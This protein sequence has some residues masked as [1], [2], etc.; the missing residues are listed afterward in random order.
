M[1]PEPNVEN[2]VLP[3]IPRTGLGHALSVWARA[4]LYSAKG[5]A[6]FVHPDWFKLR[7]GPYLRREPDK[8]DYH[9]IIR[10]PTS[11]GLP[12]RHAWRR[13]WMTAVNEDSFD[14][15]RSGQ[16]LM[17]R[18]A[19]PLHPRTVG[20]MRTA[21]P[22]RR[23]LASALES[24][25]VVA[26]A[27]KRDGTRSIGIFHRSGDF[28]GLKPAS[29]DARTLR[30]HGYGYRP[31]EYAAEALAKLREIAGWQVPAVLSTD[32]APDEV[33]V[34]LRQGG[35]QLSQTKSALA[36]MLEMS[37]HDALIIGTSSYAKWAWF[38]SDALAVTPRYAD[39]DINIIGVPEREYAWFVFD[40]ETSLND[41]AISSRF[42]C[43]LQRR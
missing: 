5:Q 37:Q 38:L 15:S 43:Q 25:S 39:L 11:W 24:I 28:R 18:D 27:K 2:L 22:F 30:V 41:E 9:R 16:F 36:N 40:N 23:Q 17:V 10:V 1:I 14:P 26:P 33:A 3:H 42:A 13:F 21:H 6:R 29:A 20:W 35:V 8:R 34:I 31:P 4:F 12:R 32:A 7:I 19:G